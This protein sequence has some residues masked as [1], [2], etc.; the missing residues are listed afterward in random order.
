M[1]RCQLAETQS[2]KFVS[3]Q[4]KLKPSS[5]VGIIATLHRECDEDI[6]LKN[7]LLQVQTHLAKQP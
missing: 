1:H 6:S 4:T 7:R 2:F 5:K 3:I